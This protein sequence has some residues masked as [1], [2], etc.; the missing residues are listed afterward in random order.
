MYRKTLALLLSATLLIG[1]IPLSGCAQQEDVSLQI[2]ATSDIHGWFVPWDFAT[3]TA[4]K[5][6]SLTYLST[7]I[8]QHKQAQPNTILVDCGDTTQA[9]YVEYFIGKPENP[10][11]AAMNHLGYDVWTFGNHEYNFNLA[12]RAKLVEQFKG[13]ALSGN[14]FMKDSGQP[15]LPGTCVVERGGVKVGFIGLTTP[16]IE[17]FEKGKS[18]LNEVDVKSPNDVLGGLIEELKQQKVDCI[19]GLI[20]AG[21]K[22]ENDAE[23]TSTVDIAN[24]YPD[25]DVIISGHAHASVESETANNV[26]LCEPY[27]NA[28]SLSVIDLRF[29]KKDGGYQ[30]VEKKASLLPAGDEEDPELLALM[31]PFKE[32]L[33]AFVN[34]PI[35]KL[36]NADLNK[37]DEIM[38]I[39]EANIGSV[40]ILNLMSTA[41]IYYSKA[42]CTLLNTDYENP[43][44]PVGDISIKNIASSYSF[45]G[46]EVSVFPVTGKQ[47]KTIMEWSAGYFNQ[48]KEGD[49]TISYN[50]ERRASKYS[51]N[52]VGGGI[53]YTIDLRQPQGSRIRNLALIEKDEL[54]NPIMTDDGAL[55]TTPITDETEIRLGTN[56][57]YM[58]QWL[59]QGGC[60]EG[61]QVA[62]V[63]NS[64]DEMGDDG[65]VRNLTI[66][67]IRDVL[68]GMVDGSKY[69]YKAWGIETGVDKESEVYK[70]AV[71]LVNSGIL[72]LPASEKGRTN[73][74]S[75][76]V[77]D[78][79]NAKK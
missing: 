62:A 75:I 28:R 68:G 38:G 60:M 67:Y 70:K 77:T 30:L 42:D 65:T 46:G 39:S 63:Y 72:K 35:G 45:T 14:V 31:T 16:L 59:A 54:G 48:I 23:G 74:G 53:S 69:T 2:L 41:G 61:Q 10:M 78:V 66:S 47:L 55:K 44:F 3:D 49:L 1:L 18:S 34:T 11:I 56:G 20:H 24:A 40:G 12:D 6:G 43:G 33:S 25:F 64:F 27:Y 76:T 26:L 8:K 58:D 19:V 71:E 22:R 57:Y 7:L 37:K 36:I 32:E 4:S 13:T 15:Y 52:F 5:R 21:L 51:S 9:N 79:E 73:I 29:E 17:K 50:P